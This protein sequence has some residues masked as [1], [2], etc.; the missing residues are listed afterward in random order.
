MMTLNEI[1]Q[2]YKIPPEETEYMESFYIFLK[3]YF[4][5]Y[6]DE[7][8][9]ILWSN[10]SVNLP[11]YLQEATKEFHDLGFFHLGQPLDFEGI[12]VSPNTLY[13]MTS[14]MT[15]F[16]LAWSLFPA[17]T[18]SAIRLLH[19]YGTEELKKQYLPLMING[20]ASGTMCLTESSSGSDLSSL[21][22]KAIFRENFYEIT[23]NKIFISGGENNLYPQICHFVLAK[24]PEGLQKEGTSG[25]SLFL[26]PKE[27]NGQSNNVYCA[28]I[29]HKMGLKYS[30]TCELIFGHKGVTK[31]F[32][33]GKEF[34]GLKQM[35]L[36]M[37]EARLY[38]A[39]QGEGQASLA[40]EL[41]HTYASSRKQF[42]KPIIEFDDVNYH[43]KKSFSMIQALRKGLL[44]SFQETNKSI[45]DFITPLLKAFATEQGFLI[46]SDCLQVFGGYGYIE[47][48]PISKVLRDSRIA[49]IYEGT[50]G[51]QAHDFF[52]RKILKNHSQN[53]DLFFSLFKDS[54][55]PSIVEG[56]S[57]SK[58]IIKHIQDNPND[59][60]S[61][62]DILRFFSYLY[63]A[64][65][66]EKD[67]FFMRYH[68]SEIYS[69]KLRI[70]G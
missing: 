31:G 68:F 9:P 24:T 66:M 59:L 41:A 44:F 14:L 64:K 22:T 7:S 19:T 48:Y 40:Y 51:I 46:S 8:E 33:V 43:L 52:S 12:E 53:L 37:N 27:L 17:L 29:E 49:M 63:L 10:G 42:G 69:L 61:S 4:H 13:A 58:V 21:Q 26:V 70:L 1:L 3:K 54:S 23:G 67:S 47:E 32:L 65:F 11:S 15:K 16:H 18:R 34:E 30:P 20:E 56:L 60:S 5:P 45:I 62:L 50:N 6:K 57:I 35:F 2:G 39:T 36:M 55:H 25:I 38:C 28:K